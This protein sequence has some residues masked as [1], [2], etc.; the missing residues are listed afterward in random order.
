MDFFDS[1]GKKLASAGKDMA[2]KTKELTGTARIKMDIKNKEDYIQQQFAK[3]GQQYYEA[4]QND[5]QDEY[6]QMLIIRNTYLE[7][8]KLKK[9]LL[10][11]KGAVEC[12]NCHQLMDATASFC[13]NCGTKLVKPVIVD[14]PETDD[15]FDDT[16]SQNV[17]LNK[18]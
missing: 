5:L 1:L 6:T 16:E 7:I 10:D 11:V 2:D 15:I 17:D 18:K 14:E 9:E 3:I 8:E 4:H 13:N 12:P